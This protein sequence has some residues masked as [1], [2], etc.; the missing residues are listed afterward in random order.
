MTYTLQ[1]FAGAFQKW[2]EDYRANPEE[3][4]TQEQASQLGVDD[5]AK[6]R[7]EFFM[8]LLKS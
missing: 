8:A 2:E 5:L 7:A 6:E 3:F 1:D 4:L